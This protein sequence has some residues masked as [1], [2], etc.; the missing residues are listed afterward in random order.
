MKTTLD[1]I[2]KYIEDYYKNYKLNDL[3]IKDYQLNGT[4]IKVE[5][6]ELRDNITDLDIK[7][8]THRRD[9]TLEIDLLE[10]ITFVTQLKI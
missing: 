6:S 4:I 5:Y 3:N 10:Y 2:K 8:N 9:T 7:Y 1:L